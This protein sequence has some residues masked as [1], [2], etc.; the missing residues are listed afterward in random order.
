MTCIPAPACK[1]ALRQASVRWPGRRTSSDGI[2]ASPQ[3]TKQNPTSDHEVGLAFDLSHDPD[4]G[5]DT[6]LIADLMRRHPDPR[7]KYVI[8][9]HR[10]WNPSIAPDWRTYVGVN[11]HTH[12]MHVSIKAASRDDTSEWWGVY[13]A[14]SSVQPSSAPHRE[15][16]MRSYYVMNIEP[17]G[18]GKLTISDIR[19]DHTAA[20]TIK[21]NDDGG[22]VDATIQPFEGFKGMLALAAKGKPG[23]VGVIVSHT[24]A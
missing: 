3:H 9:N 7:V 15:D 23:L 2:C 16:E 19:F 20:V 8:S 5:V 18:L 11:P 14:A 4:H 24:A 6:F 12:H 21:A 22:L 10:I 17:N 1:A 13:Q